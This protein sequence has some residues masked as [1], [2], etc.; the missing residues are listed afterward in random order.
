MVAGFS[1][2]WAYAEPFMR[3]L[4]FG[5]LM[6]QSL[7]Q[8]DTF[9]QGR[10]HFMTTVNQI[11]EWSLALE[12]IAR[13][14]DARNV[15]YSLAGWNVARFVV[16]MSVAYL[17]SRQIQIL[18]ISSAAN[19]IQN[20]LGKLSLVAMTVA[21][22]GLFVLGQTMLAV[23]TLMYLCVGVLDRYN[24][25]P[26]S[27]QRVV[28]HADFFIGNLTGLYLG[29]NFIRIVCTLNLIV[30]AVRK[31]FDYR[32][33]VEEKKENEEVLFD[34]EKEAFVEEVEED[35]ATLIS[36]R[37]LEQLTDDVECPI[38]KAHIH[39]KSLP[40][41]DEDAQ[42]EDILDLYDQIDWTAHEHVV[43]SKLAK[44][45][46]WLE[47][48]QFKSKPMDYFKRN[49]RHMVESIKNHDILEGKP[50]SYE[51]LDYYCRFISQELKKQDEMTQADMLIWMGVDGGPY[52]G[53]GKFGVVEEIY[54]SLISQATGLS[55][56]TRILA[57]EQQERQRVWQHI[58]QLVWTMTPFTQFFGY[59]SDINAIHNANIFIN[60][61]QA[62]PK[63]GIP[64]QTAKN[65]QTATINPITHYLAFSFVH[66][67]ED[68]F[69]KGRAVPQCYISIDQ[70]SDNDWWQV[71]KWVHLKIEK[72]SPKPYDQSTIIERFSETIGLPQIPKT[73]IYRW[74]AEW[75]YRQDDLTDTEKYKLMDELQNIPQKNASGKLV[76]NFNNEP[77]EVDGKIRPKFLKAMLI[78]M[79]IFDKPVDMLLNENIVADKSLDSVESEPIF[80]G[81]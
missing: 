58:Y 5:G 9:R 15:N 31:Y 81:F 14:L 27:A 34:L 36:F 23:T 40:K 56:E 55:L 18:H 22:V 49:L 79:G 21:T 6:N 77:F 39:K 44:D 48:E 45:K 80:E 71:W 75:I 47:V 25:L 20:H 66:I 3:G 76:L 11:L 53:T 59:M 74:W 73:D 62:G 67:A 78:E 37:E 19:F 68:C 70:S 43:E 65:D 38:R 13:C 4:K 72:I 35:T 64:D 50:A 17:A 7:A 41:V 1:A 63:F 69:W 8:E 61:I 52:C 60:L 42:I 33:L 24:I 28:H 16:P 46:H 2:N 26:E 54:Q 30:G 57:C 12:Q 29:G 51:M 10:H 32:R